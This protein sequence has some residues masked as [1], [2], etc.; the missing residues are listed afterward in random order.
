MSMVLYS[1]C[2]FSPSIKDPF[3]LPSTCKLYLH[4]GIRSHAPQQYQFDSLR[5]QPHRRVACLGHVKPRAQSSGLSQASNNN[6]TVK[7]TETV[8]SILSIQKW[9]RKE[10][11]QTSKGTATHAGGTWS[12]STP[13]LRTAHT[14]APSSGLGAQRSPHLSLA[15]SPTVKAHELTGR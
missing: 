8:C 9:G 7:I 2:I 5:V 11:G 15:S 14:S 10:P 12:V 13:Q 3:G 4:C 6:K 1:E